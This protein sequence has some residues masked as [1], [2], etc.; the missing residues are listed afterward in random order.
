MSRVLAML[1]NEV[2][3]EVVSTKAN[4]IHEMEVSHFFGS[5]NSFSPSELI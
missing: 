2:D 3:M 1:L 5:N 4:R